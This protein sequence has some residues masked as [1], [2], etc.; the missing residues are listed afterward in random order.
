M[1]RKCTKCGCELKTKAKFCPECGALV[2]GESK[3]KKV[4]NEQA[5]DPSENGG[6]KGKGKIIAGAV[7]VAA[8]VLGVGGFATAKMMN[9]KSEEPVKKEAKADTKKKETKETKKV[10]EPKTYHYQW[11]LN[12]TVEADQIYYVTGSDVK[13]PFN[14]YHKQLDSD[15]AVIE[16]DGLKGWIDTSG[17][18]FADINCNNIVSVDG[19]D[20]FMK[21]SDGHYQE[22]MDDEGIWVR[23][24]DN[25]L[26]FVDSYDFP[27][28]DSEEDDALDMSAISKETEDLTNNPYWNAG[29]YY[30]GE[31]RYVHTSE[32]GETTGNEVLEETMPM[33]ESDKIITKLAE[34]KQLNGKYAIVSNGEP[35]TDFVYDEC[36]S[37]SEGLFAVCQDG[38]W[39][40]VDETGKVV[41]PMEY[42]ASWNRYTADEAQAANVD[43]EPSMDNYCYAAENGYVNLR[44]GDEWK[45]CGVNGSEVIPFGEFDEILPVAPNNLCWVKKDGKWGVIMILD[46]EVTSTEFTA[47]KDAYIDWINDRSDDYTYEL[48]EMD[49]SVIPQIV[50]IAKNSSEESVLAT[51]EYVGGSV[52]TEDVEAKSIRYLPNGNL[53]QISE[54]SMDDYTDEFYMVQDSY[55]ELVKYGGYNANDEE[56]LQLDANGNPIYEYYWGEDDVSKEQYEKN[57]ESLMPVDQA[58]TLGKNSASADEIISQIRNYKN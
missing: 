33:R 14:E 23:D 51:Y 17:V 19:E 25:S 56:E 49:G 53:I 29:Y 30:D 22:Y 21:R 48:I 6:K 58:V 43:A 7:I 31:V 34:W 40:Y 3:E 1:A 50:A 10:E 27:D 15:Y 12:P 45:L 38:K 8:I 55:W 44:K 57:I 35:A 41:I 9:K 46:E 54:G 2:E 37:E 36:G 32:F 24:I 4:K 52:A 47:W 20:C 16:K 5:Q 42:D 28:Y 26:D 11:I 13:K 39:G 18:L